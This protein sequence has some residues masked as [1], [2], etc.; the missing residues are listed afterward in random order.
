MVYM[1]PF[2]PNSMTLCPGRSIPPFANPL[3]AEA[4]C[5][6]GARSPGSGCEVRARIVPGLISCSLPS[7]CLEMSWVHA[8]RSSSVLLWQ[9]SQ[10]KE[11]DKKKRRKILFLNKSEKKELCGEQVKYI[12]QARSSVL[13]QN[14][15]DSH[16]STEGSAGG[17][18]PC[19]ANTLVPGISSCWSCQS[20]R[21][22][23]VGAAII[24]AGLP[25]APLRPIALWE[26]RTWGS[27]S[28][29]PTEPSQVSQR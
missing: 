22:A 5:R 17:E 20:S 9:L 18:L 12:F 2:Q 26:Q 21:S 27:H 13:P 23:Q 14:Q 15:Q 4:Q 3:L 1:G 24:A 7:S 28:Q 19:N 16:L 25:T 8:D 29:S 6:C 10:C 11:K